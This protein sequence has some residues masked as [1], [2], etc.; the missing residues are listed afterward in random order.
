MVCSTL[1]FLLAAMLALLPGN[2]VDQSLV[3][4]SGS[5][6]VVSLAIVPALLDA[7]ESR[8][9]LPTHDELTDGDGAALCAKAVRA[10][11]EGATAGHL[12]EWLNIPLD[13][14]PKPRVQEA[15]EQAA[16][17]LDFARRG[18][19]C[20]TWD[21][22]TTELLGVPENLPAYRHLASLLCLQTRIQ[23]AE[24]QY[25]RAIETMQ[26]NIS[27]ARHV[28]AGPA[29]AQGIISLAMAR[30]ALR[31]LE[32][33]TQAPGSPNLYTALEALPHPL[34]DLNETISKEEQRLGSTSQYSDAVRAML[35]RRAES[36]FKRVRQMMNQLDSA[37]A[38]FQGI[39]A[40]RHYAATHGRSLPAELADIT[41]LRVPVDPATGIPFP[42]R[43]EGAKAI[44]EVA[45]PKG[46]RSADMIRYEITIAR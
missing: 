27:T 43:L 3:G 33:W 18:A 30:I 39:E 2:Q 21:W 25:K 26:T 5:A 44:L 16:A 28:A 31:N 38:A 14:L 1:A 34:I 20:A 4:D 42:Y 40:I 35:Q 23:I 6:R 19:K 12:H 24:K 8:S 17:S 7:R 22:P 15:I 10:L 32:D 41:D 9:L 37:V 13:E 36:S 11:P 29:A 45:P 46:G